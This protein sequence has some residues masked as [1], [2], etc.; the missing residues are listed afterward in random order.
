MRMPLATA[1]M[2]KR[3]AGVYNLGRLRRRIADRGPEVPRVDI[4][5]SGIYPRSGGS[6]DN[7]A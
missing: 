1:R 5:S 3:T 2:E 4:S 6:A 7:P